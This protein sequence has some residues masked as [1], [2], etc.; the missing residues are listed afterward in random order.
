MLIQSFWECIFIY[1]YIFM[2]TAVATAFIQTKII[3]S[4]EHI[5]VQYKERK[6]GMKDNE[7]IKRKYQ[8]IN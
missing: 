5:R 2:I 7:Y 1:I 3:S 4:K 8:S 6:R